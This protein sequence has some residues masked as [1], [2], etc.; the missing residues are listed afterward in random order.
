VPASN[1]GS[2]SKIPGRGMS[3]LGPLVMILVKS[4]HKY[5]LFLRTYKPTLYIIMNLCLLEILFWA[6]VQQF[7]YGISNVNDLLEALAEERYK[8]RHLSSRSPHPLITL[9]KDQTSL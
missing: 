1:P 4:L 9:R 6:E 7:S 5:K 8:R 3:V 2:L